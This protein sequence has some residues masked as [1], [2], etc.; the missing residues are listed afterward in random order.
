MSAF[1]LGRPPR[2]Y[3]PAINFLYLIIII[4]LLG[5]AYYVGPR[6]EW[7]KPQ[8]KL[9][10]DSDVLGLA[11]LEIAV[12]DQGT[13]LKSVTATLSSGGAE[14]GLASEQYARPVTEKTITVAL[15]S[16]L[17]GVKE[18]PA[19]L[20]VSARDNSLWNFF[21][22]NET[23]IQKN[24]TIDITPPTLELFADDRYVN[25]GGVGMIVYKP[26]ADTVT[27]GVKIG[28]YFFPGANG[29]I[30]EQ[31]DHFVVFFAHPYNVAEAAKAMLV[32]ADKAGNTKEMRL[33][34][35]LKNV[36]YKKST[37]AVTDE[38]IEGKV[39]P[40]LNDVGARQ[41]TPKEVFIRVNKGLRKENEAKIAEITKKFTPSILWKGAFSQLSNS[42]VEANF[43]D[44]RT[45]VYNNE[46]IDN[47][48]HLGYDLS[49]TKHYPAEAANSG[50]VAFVGD[51]GI[52]G[53]T[54]ILDHGLGLFTLYAHLSSIDVKVGDSIKQQQAIGK[55]GETGL[56]AGDHL[57]Y[58]VYL[59][60]VAILPVEW[61]DQKWIND[62]IQPKLD[63]QSGETIAEAQES[64]AARKP[65][66]KRRR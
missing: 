18:G 48:Y 44:A 62:N 66:R 65:A 26:S 61:W 16:K 20:R 63:G 45:Y 27:T 34:Y 25:F 37:I 47:A 4:G 36:K 55:T 11:P 50:T 31:P 58:G 64:K 24:I 32:A 53:N 5:G 10:P 23:V 12:A 30:K 3:R 14:H 38:F 8:I 22:G 57:H 54:V 21:R 29:Q 49:V 33:V 19:V 52:Y 43:A 40:L 6:F 28:D 13:G 39:A 42:K 60:G 59:H 17:T 1:E 7:H 56:A 51:L 41:G 9:T 35:E 15:S 2:N 46:A